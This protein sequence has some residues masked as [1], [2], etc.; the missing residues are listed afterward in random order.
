MRASADDLARA[1]TTIIENAATVNAQLIGRLLG[2]RFD[3]NI[4]SSLDLPGVLELT[5]RSD[6]AGCAETARRL[7]AEVARFLTLYDWVDDKSRLFEGLTYARAATVTRLFRLRRSLD[8]L[9]TT[10]AGGDASGRLPV[11]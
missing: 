6:P 11:Q 9:L 8:E 4:L 5:A 7:R 3:P 2:E 10:L 1:R